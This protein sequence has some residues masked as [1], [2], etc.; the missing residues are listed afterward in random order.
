MP[1]TRPST[2]NT[3][4]IAT[5][6]SGFHRR[7]N[8]PNL[9]TRSNSISKLDSPPGAKRTTAMKNRPRYSCQAA[10]YSDS[11]TVKK[12]PTTAPS[13]G[14]KKKPMPPM[15][16]NSRMAPERIALTFSALT[17][18]KLIAPSAPETPAKKADRIKVR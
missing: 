3:A 5:A 15:K 4:G 2:P 17:I 7:E 10:V 14:P 8:L 18:S 1:N 13:N 9:A 16:T 11:I 12:T 6:S